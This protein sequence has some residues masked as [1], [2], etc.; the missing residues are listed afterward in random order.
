MKIL[1]SIAIAAALVF[2]AFVILNHDNRSAASTAPGAPPTGPSS[3]VIESD[4]RVL[5]EG[6]FYILSF[7]LARAEHVTVSVTL[8]DGAPIDSYFV[9]EQGL[10]AWKAMAGGSHAIPF[11][12]RQELSMAPLA[13]SYS[14][15]ALVPAGMHALIIDNS[16]FGATAPPF[17]FF[18]HSPALVGYTVSISD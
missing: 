11:R 4:A 2:L 17:H 7:N 8:K 12:Y 13:G 1:G 16:N 5:Q 9:A 10:N 3:Q 15:T 14:H 18:K 6:H